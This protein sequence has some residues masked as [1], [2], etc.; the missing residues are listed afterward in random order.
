MFRDWSDSAVDFA[1]AFLDNEAGEIVEMSAQARTLARTIMI[2]SQHVKSEGKSA[3]PE[4][5]CRH[6]VTG[7]ESV[8]P[9][10]RGIPKP[11]FGSSPA[12]GQGSNMTQEQRS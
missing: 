3:S 8:G 9:M 1:E 12:S 4:S 5:A 7:R 2:L 10:Q 6:V 11:R